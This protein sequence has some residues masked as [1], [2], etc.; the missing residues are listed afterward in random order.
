MALS[1]IT[2]AVASFTDL[3]IGD[4]LTLSDDLL[5]ASDAAVVKFGADAEVTLT[6]V[7]NTGLLL[8]STSVIQFNDASQNIG[9]PSAT[10]LDI[11]ATDEI[12]LNATL[13]DVNGNLDISGT[14][15]VT[16]VLTTTAATVFNGGFASNADST[17]G[18]DKKIQFRDTGLTI[19]SSADGQLDIVADTEVQIAATTIDINGNVEISGT[20]AQV[21]VSTSTAKDIFNAGMSLKNGATSAGFAEFFEDSDNGTNKVTLIGPAS[22]ADVT[23]VLP[24]TAGTLA[25]TSEVATTES[26]Q[27]VVGAMFSSNTETNI[28]VTYED[29]DGTIDLVVDAAQPNVTSLGTLTTLTVDNIIINGSNIGHTSD[30]DA[31]AIASNGQLTLTQTLIGTAL[32]IS[33][34]ID[35][36]GTT[37]LDVVDIDGAVD[38][39]STLQVDGAI[40]GS[41]TIQGTTITATTAFVPDASDGAALGTSSLEFS[42]LFLADGAVISFGDDQE[43]TLTHV[44]DDGLILKHVGTADGKEPSFSF[45]AGDNDIAANDVLGS[46]FFKAPDEGAGTDAVLVAAGIEAVSEGDF[47]ASNNAT[48]LSFLTGASEAAAEKMSLSSGGNLT[49][50][51]NLGVGGTAVA[52]TDTD[53]SNTGSVTLDFGANQNFVLTLTGN[54]TL[55]NPSTEQ[56]GQS[57]FIVCIQDGTGSRTLS[58]GTDYETAGGAGITLTSTA[59]ATDIIPYVVAAAGRILLGAPQLAFS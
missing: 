55:A 2:E 5:I 29:S 58:L 33:G 20:L 14:A 30:T 12:E 28:T 10:V 27:D 1:R 37:N 26:I 35:V 41:S 18:T 24:A 17:M 39:A 25:L 36:D 53:T 52:N 21:G 23:V 57:G 42:D 3:T 45:H 9:A 48:K 46:I 54:T 6:H 8:N 43:I 19:N 50:S 40:T 38:M 13:I 16:G 11:N 56:V 44:A 22:T 4:D 31:I 59:S 49:V 47:S 32:D 7:H 51:G 15:L 34:D